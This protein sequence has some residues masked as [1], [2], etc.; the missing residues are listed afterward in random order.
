MEERFDEI[1]RADIKRWINYRYGRIWAPDPWSFK[2]TTQQLTV[3]AGA[4]SA[5]LGTLQKIISLRDETTSPLYTSM[6]AFRPEDFYAYATRT[7][8]VPYGYTV[9]GSNVYFDAPSLSAR[10]MRVVG[11]LKFVSLVNDTD[12]PL[13]PEEFHMILVHGAASEGLRIENDPSWQGA[14]EDFR[15]ALMDMKASY[16]VVVRQGGNAYPAWP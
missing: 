15:A 8:N 4:S 7:Q 12:T 3:N 1:K 5:S 11:E 9:I 10:T 13:I 16:L 14:E 6:D 2:L